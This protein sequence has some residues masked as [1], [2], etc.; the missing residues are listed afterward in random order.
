MDSS[1]AFRL[2]Y[3]GLHRPGKENPKAEI[4]VVDTILLDQHF[5]PN[6]WTFTTKSGVV[7]R[8]KHKNVNWSS[9]R[10]AIRRNAKLYP[11]KRVAIL[12]FSD[13]M[14]TE[15]Q[16]H[17]VATSKSFDSLEVDLGKDVNGTLECIQMYGHDLANP[18]S[19]VF[20]CNY[21]C[22]QG[23]TKYTSVQVKVWPE[24][25]DEGGEEDGSGGNEDRERFAS[26][27]PWRHNTMVA[28]TRSIVR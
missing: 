3:K 18:G 20:H 5:Q 23:S 27:Q 13:P 21:T 22:I 11:A 1:R 6:L 24:R 28:T 15:L 25:E 12:R 10:N 17:L 14:A 26:V 8:K 4:N 2:I 19:G 16:T 9:I 7:C